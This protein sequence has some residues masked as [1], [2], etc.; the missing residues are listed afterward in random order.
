MISQEAD[1]KTIVV[2]F[3][4][5][6]ASAVAAK[7]TIELYG[8]ECRVIVANSPIKE[9]HEDN[10]RFLKDISEWIQ[11]PIIEVKNKDFP[12]ASIVEV[13]DKRKY[14][15]GIIGA[16]CTMIL[17]KE[18]RYQFEKSVKINF[19][20]LGFTVDEWERQKHFNEG[21]RQNTIPVLTTSLITKKDCFNILRK[22]NIKIPEI[23]TL[24]FPNAN[25]VGCVKATSPSYWNLVR[26]CFPNV[27][28]CRAEQSRR[29]GVRLVRV[30]GK[31]I[32]LDELKKSDTGAPIKSWECGIF[33]K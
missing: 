11:Q 33:C 24:K 17:K 20:V 29:L 31:R 23:Y 6:A 12:N 28:E 10:R 18:A 32:F 7:R 21:E 2:W 27:F 13:F 3:S 30:K 1:K 8:K 22:Q 19:H 25:C 15:G 26:E 5:G 16:P 9:E 14:M 4:C